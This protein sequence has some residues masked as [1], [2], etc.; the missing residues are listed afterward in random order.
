MMQTWQARGLLKQAAGFD[1]ERLRAE[2][3]ILHKVD[4]KRD[5]G[6]AAQGARR[7]RCQH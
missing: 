5:L 6:A 3:E 2:M 4:R 1:A 7:V